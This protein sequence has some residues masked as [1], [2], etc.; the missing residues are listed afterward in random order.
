M[1]ARRRE[2]GEVWE[3]KGAG[4]GVWW[5]AF[6]QAGLWRDAFGVRAWWDAAWVVLGVVRGLFRRQNGK[7][8]GREGW[9]VNAACLDGRGS[10]RL[11]GNG[12]LIEI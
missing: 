9:I 7:G 12:V 2:G 1:M 6:T 4:R 3:R 8:V 10:G 5:W 11:I